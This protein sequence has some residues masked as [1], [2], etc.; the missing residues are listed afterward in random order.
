MSLREAVDLTEN[1]PAQGGF[2]A[3]TRNRALRLGGAAL[4]AL[5][6]RTLLPRS[7]YA[8]PPY[9]CYGL[10]ECSS[11][12]SSGGCPG[13]TPYRGVCVESQPTWYCWT[14][15][16]SCWYFQCCDYKQSGN[17]CICSVDLNT[18]CCA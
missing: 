11:C 1:A 17:P 8:A 18:W 9:P 10:D 7:V 6:A 15:C 5:A 16:A 12:S 13:C 3:I 4:F 14:T 2:G